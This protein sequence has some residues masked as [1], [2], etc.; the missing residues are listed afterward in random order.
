MNY[1]L[2]LTVCSDTYRYSVYYANDMTSLPIMESL[3]H[4]KDREDIYRVFVKCIDTDY[5]EE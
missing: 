5:T 2:Y 1:Y 4:Y 3:I